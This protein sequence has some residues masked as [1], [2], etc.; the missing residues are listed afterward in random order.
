MPSVGGG[1]TFNEI[2][3]NQY[4][5]YLV[6]KAHQKF[7]ECDSVAI[8]D[9]PILP[10]THTIERGSCGQQLEVFVCFIA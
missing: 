3:G 5:G 4:C 6:I 2:S 1:Y 10:G 8:C 9:T 7:C